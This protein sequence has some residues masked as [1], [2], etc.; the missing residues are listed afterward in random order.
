MIH[1]GR[2][3]KMAATI[4]AKIIPVAGSPIEM[5]RGTVVNKIKYAIRTP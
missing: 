1:K 3:K 2:L 4:V 5:R